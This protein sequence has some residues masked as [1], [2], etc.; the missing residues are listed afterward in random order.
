[1]LLCV[2]VCCC[3]SFHSEAAG[4][5]DHSV[6]R[7]PWERNEIPS[8]YRPPKRLSVY[9]YI[10]ALRDR[11]RAVG[12]AARESRVDGWVCDVNVNMINRGIK[13]Y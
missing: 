9:P 13:W 3:A 5:S 7:Y 10:Y 2:A 4:R 8:V 6:P 1:M 11:E 12:G